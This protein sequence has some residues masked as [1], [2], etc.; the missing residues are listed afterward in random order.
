MDQS[1]VDEYRRTRES[2]LE[3]KKS[4]DHLECEEHALRDKIVE[5]LRAGTPLSG[6]VL[7]TK[8]KPTVEDWPALY[9]YILANNAFDI[10]HRRVTEAAVQ[11]RWIAGETVPGV[12]RFPVYDVKL[13]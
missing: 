2:R 3:L 13:A 7:I 6:V 10:L 1:I 4:L 12:A 5:Q 9:K 8:I 11:E